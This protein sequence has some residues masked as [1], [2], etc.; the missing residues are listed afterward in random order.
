[1]KFD[2]FYNDYLVENKHNLKAKEQGDLF[3]RFTK[4]Y[5]EGSSKYQ[6]LI[7][8][9]YYW[10]DW[11]YS[12]NNQDIG[13]DLVAETHDGKFFAVQCKFYLRETVLSKSHVD[14]FLSASSKYFYV[15][16]E[17]HTFSQRILVATVDRLGRNTI[18]TLSR[19]QPKCRTILFSDLIEDNSVDFDYTVKKKPTLK[20]TVVKKDLREYQEEAVSRVNHHFKHNDRGKLI[21][22]CG[23]GKTFTSLRIMEKYLKKNKNT[24]NLMLFVVP[25]LS[26]V[27]QTMQEW[28]EN[29]NE[30]Q[31]HLVVSS[32]QS[33][34]AE[35]IQEDS[36]DRFL[37]SIPS[38][39]DSEIIKEFL[40]RDYSKT[41][42]V[43][44]T[45]RSLI[46]IVEAQK[47][48]NVKFD[49][50]FCDEAHRCT[51][52]IEDTH[53]S[54]KED[55]LILD[56]NKILAGKRVFMTATPRVYTKALNENAKKKNIILAG[57]DNEEFFGKEV[58]KYGFAQAIKDRT[59]CPVELV[60]LKSNTEKTDEEIKKQ[61]EF[62]SDIM[63][64]IWNLLRENKLN[65]VLVFTNKI[66]ESKQFKK[67][68]KKYNNNLLIEHI[69][70]GMGGS[71]RKELLD[72]FKR[73]EK[74]KI[75]MLSNVKCLSEGVDVPKIDAIVFMK[76][77][78]API[79]VV[80]A[81]GRAIRNSKNKKRGY[82]IIPVLVQ[83]Q[84][85]ERESIHK[86]G[87][88]LV[89]QVSDALR[90]HDETLDMSVNKIRYD[91]INPNTNY[92]SYQELSGDI[93]KGSSVTFTVWDQD[94]EVVISNYSY[95]KSLFIRNIVA[96]SID[97]SG[98][99]LDFDIYSDD[100][101]E[102]LKDIIK[103][104]NKEEKNNKYLL[105]FTK[106][107][108]EHV[109]AS[110]DK[111]AVILMIAQHLITEP[112]FETLFSN[113]DILKN[114]AL[115]KEINKIISSFGKLK[116]E[117][118][119]KL[120][121]FYINVRDR[122]DGIETEKE[123]QE[124]LNE[125]YEKFFNFIDKKSADRDGIV[126]TPQEIV[127][128]MIKTTDEIMIKEFSHGLEKKNIKI[129]DPF[130]GT[131]NFIVNLL[132]YFNEKG[133]S[134]DFID[135]KYKNEIMAN[136]ISLLPYYIASCN[137][138]ERYHKITSKF[139]NFRGICLVDY[140]S[141]LKEQQGSFKE[142]KDENIQRIEKQKEENFQVFIGNPP[143][144]V[145]QKNENDNN[146][147]V[148]H[149]DLE[150]RIKETYMANNSDKK[151]LAKN[152]YNSFFKAFRIASDKLENG[153]IALITPNQFLTKNTTEGF[154]VCLEQEFSS[155]YHVDLKGNC[156]HLSKEDIKKQGGNVFGIM[157]GVGITFL[158]KNKEKLNNKA[159]IYL[160]RLHD[161]T[162]RKQKI[163]EI[164]K[165]EHL[166][167]I[168]FEKIVSVKN[169]WIDFG[170]P[171]WQNFI[172]LR[173]SKNE[174]IQDGIFFL[175]ESGQTTRRDAWVY[176]FSKEQ[177]KEKINKFLN[178]YNQ[179][180]EKY[181]STKKDADDIITT[182]ITKIK[183][184]S[185]LKNTFKRRLSINYDEKHIRLSY[186]SLFN[187]QYLYYSDELISS[188]SKGF[189]VF[190]NDKSN[191]ISIAFT[192]KGKGDFSCCII[193]Q[194]VANPC[195]QLT[196]LSGLYR[197]SPSGEKVSN[198][199]HYAVNLFSNFYDKKVTEKEI[200]AYIYCI[201][202]SD[203]YRTT[204]EKDLFRENAKIP[205]F[206]S[207]D[208]F[209]SC[210]VIGEKLKDI[211]LNY[212]KFKKPRGVKVVFKKPILD[213]SQEE[214]YKVHK[215]I[216]SKDSKDKSE[217]KYNKYYTIKNI[218]QKAFEWKVNGNSAIQ[219]LIKGYQIKKPKKEQDNGFIKDPNTYQGS[220]Y[221][222]DLVL[223]VI[224]VSIK[225]ADL[226]AEIPK[227]EGN[228]FMDSLEKFRS[229]A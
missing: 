221:I 33:I 92:T 40:L 228:I 131:G 58:F 21:M 30:K 195:L 130:T 3:E 24:S 61:K 19:Q 52:I 167:K 201:L 87:Y 135:Y 76:P 209:S 218:P 225:T 82:I 165:L 48:T 223:S 97:V 174:V 7:K 149:K 196:R 4:E 98:G 85:S 192:D 164:Q 114:N 72:W 96:K 122:I 66:N 197:F 134:N 65:K 203:E 132:D 99:E 54:A 47:E 173:D 50:A 117:L 211:H 191:N 111:D 90:E 183:W 124:L 139:D 67:Q 1:M 57:M 41:R 175:A 49:I 181:K 44:S 110:I 212:E 169:N 22:A 93:S 145:G 199:T 144:N 157:T 94:R 222:F 202:N 176:D 217:L 18:T 10:N 137:I 15:D 38:T 68:F 127:Q 170:K 125:F 28:N 86:S 226:L 147:K 168:P 215:M 162:N 141:L 81:I 151:A 224:N 51:G 78:K 43:F 163:E 2:Q 71:K 187:K 156:R 154:R 53:E 112:V 101:K 31:I 189:E 45:Y 83:K 180:L 120:D 104:I 113:K 153:V 219:E 95:Q 8:K 116:Q 172:K 11:E 138:E 171:E 32:D 55:T 16:G 152:L 80:Q 155:V 46:K 133:V 62:P 60:I 148:K 161:S 13:I 79:E 17:R 35:N 37:S 214:Q 220:K 64:P 210:V 34:R 182:D 20:K 23:S 69:D 140:F 75:K 89:K 166:D 213:I 42:V 106:N 73:D 150:E 36:K 193:D 208:H 159:D 186:K 128:F 5:L 27:S 136:E 12:E 6:G 188:K 178:T 29:A 63:E 194:L 184:D 204:Y 143:Y 129:V 115:A 88:T 109:N 108:Q 102:T 190:P 74:N 158:V 146:K 121:R 70:G 227:L 198:I 14:T 160:H 123:R 179:D 77:K 207:Y 100:I 126:Y 107:I 39:T 119:Q 142:C 105:E 25:S 216:L 26:L 200:F 56:K 103:Y 206:K 9:V 59:L 185:T 91:F 177:L 229:K 84:K 205:L 118:K